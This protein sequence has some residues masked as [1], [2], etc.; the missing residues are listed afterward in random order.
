M[1]RNRTLLIAALVVLILV[2]IVLAVRGR[3][4]S[5]GTMALLTSPVRR[6]DIVSTI[7]ATGTVEPQEVVDV[8][9]QVAGIIVAFGTDAGG[10]PVDYGS[11]VNQG[12]VLARIDP[13]IY[14]SDVQSAQATLAQNRAALLKAQADLQQKNAQLA[15]AAA[16]WKRAQELGPSEALSK[17]SYDAYKAGYEVALA[18]VR[19]DEASV[20]QAK[21][22]IAQSEADLARAQ[23]NLGY[24]TIVSPVQGVIIDRRVN[25]G[26]TVVA[27]LNAPSLFL[28]ARD[29]RRIQVWVQV[30]EADIGQIRVGQPVTFTVD[31][32]PGRTFQG[33]VS[34]VRLN[35]TM[36]Q[37]V[38]TYTVIVDSDNSSGILLPYLTANAQFE[39][40]R[41]TG[42]LMVPNGAFRWLPADVSQVAPGA[43]AEARSLIAG[44]SSGAP[45]AAAP[46]R[47]GSGVIWV[48][49]GGN[50]RPVRVATGLTDGT[51][52]EVSGPGVSEGEAVVIGERSAGT[53]APSS[54]RSP[55][56]P[57]FKR[58]AGTKQPPAGGAPPA[59][60]R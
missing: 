55:F 4:G 15:Q 30:N 60:K 51:D 10:H 25:I 13:S 1:K 40:G 59:K 16:D 33:Q 19:V 50:V 18:N 57:Q 53:G 17:T 42:V 41:A 11:P 9:A 8:G 2:V 7:G 39:T 23:R 22:A 38:V 6:G 45:I 46:G 31:A 35:A 37:N 21:G 28:I 43:R 32:F 12:T 29:L 14:Q 20:E 3:R 54:G 26:Q 48:E 47:G 49:Q 5:G 34:Q 44:E 56:A 27:S 24:T 58:G 36:T 52:T